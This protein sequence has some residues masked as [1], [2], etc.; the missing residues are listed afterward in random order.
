MVIASYNSEKYL[1]E[2]IRSVVR[3]TFIHWELIVVDD[4]STDRSYHIAK[5]WAKAEKRISVTR[6]SA[7]GGAAL[8]RNAGISIAR[9]RYIA[10]C[11]SD[12]VWLPIKL[13]AQELTFK[14][15]SAALC[16][17]G[18]SRCDESGNP[19][20]WPVHARTSVE[21]RDL[22]RFNC[23][24][25][26]TVA[27]DTEALGKIYFPE[28]RMRQDYALW[29]LIL[30]ENREAV[31]ISEPLVK[32]RVRAGSVS[33]NKIRAALSHWEV[34]TQY[35]GQGLIR[36]GIYFLYYFSRNFLRAAAEFFMRK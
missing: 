35:G 26:S 9:G 23:I 4:C 21:F 29:L 2:T 5:M 12:D 31:G 22:L 8:A 25:L 6:L 30:R 28:L 13:E 3:Q 36:S 34:L 32:Y 10:F 33:S 7:N 15:S 20:G 19:M 1:D 16:F 14:R 18:F 11:D 27:Y 17:T 24:G